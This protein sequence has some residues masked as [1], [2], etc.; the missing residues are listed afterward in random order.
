M[1]SQV[2]QVVNRDFGGNMSLA[3]RTIGVDYHRLRRVCIGRWFPHQRG[4]AV[5]V[6][7]KVMTWAGSHDQVRK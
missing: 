3:A 1:S 7:E 5:D 4:S 6:W 2:C